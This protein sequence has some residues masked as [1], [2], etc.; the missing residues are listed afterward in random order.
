MKTTIFGN[1]QC[2]IHTEM[3]LVPLGG[4]K[5]ML[6]AIR[7]AVDLFNNLHHDPHSNLLTSL[8]TLT[9]RTVFPVKRTQR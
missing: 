3:P 2:Q 8:S 1:R 6:V 7:H 9:V 4:F 5:R